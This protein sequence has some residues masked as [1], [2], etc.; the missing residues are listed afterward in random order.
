M[1]LQ[2]I[3]E[4]AAELTG[5]RYAALGVIGP[6]G[7]LSDFLTHGISPEERERIGALPK[8]HGILGVLIADPRPLRLDDLHQDPRSVGFPPNHP[9]MHTFLGAPLRSRGQVFGNLYLTEK[10]GGGEFTAEDEET[11]VLLAAHA[12]AAIEN[13]HLA[14]AAAVRERRFQALYEISAAI[15]ASGDYD[16]VLGLI[17]A[18]ARELAGADLAMIAVPDDRTGELHVQA[19]DGANEGAVRGRRFPAPESVSGEVM[20]TREPILLEAAL[21]DPRVNQPLMRAAGAGPAL[22]LP[23]VGGDRVFGTLTMV[24]LVGG[25]PFT[26]DDV[27]IVETFANQAAL[28]LAYGGAQEQMRRVAVLEDRER[29]ARD[30]HDGVIQSLFASGMNLQAAVALSDDPNVARRIEGVVGELDYV[31][32][33]LRNYIFRLRPQ[34]VSGRLDETLYRLAAEF[35]ERTGIVTAVSVDRGAAE[36]LKDQ[37]ADL[38][39]IVHEALSNVGRHSGASTCRLSLVQE[40]DA[41]LLEVDDDGRGFDPG[42]SKQGM[43]LRNLRERAGSL[44]G[45]FEVRSS[46]GS[47][48]VVRLVLRPG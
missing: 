43:G 11:L 15:L 36:R 19:A 37:E 48:T 18:R 5:A 26:D 31:I 6:E 14:E 8:G 2:R 46:P 23:L 7:G 39:Q 10:Q 27:R 44:G 24:K 9:P 42:S 21:A 32:R 33:E 16:A 45:D 30:L 28:A 35:E 25:R 1:V 17:A 29:I 4:L 41:S 40:G 13:A 34:Q 47:G 38:V 20:L 22:F 12:G 3:V